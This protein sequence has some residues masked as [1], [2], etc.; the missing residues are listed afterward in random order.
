MYRLVETHVEIS[1]R[2][3]HHQLLA[4]KRTAPLVVVTHE[5]ALG[6][7]RRGRRR[8]RLVAP[9]AGVAVRRRAAVVGAGCRGAVAG[10]G[11]AALLRVVFGVRAMRVRGGGGVVFAAAVVA[12]G[13]ARRTRRATRGVR[14]S[15]VHRL[16][17]GVARGHRSTA[18]VV[19]AGVR[20]GTLRR[21]GAPARA[22]AARAAGVTGGVLRVERTRGTMARG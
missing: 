10:V 8:R 15:G 16:L 19:V 2:Q 3:T 12:G 22:G 7:A 11:A 17:Q 9:A 20:R 18:A 1:D 21:R 6:A 5:E 4:D 14:R 13:G